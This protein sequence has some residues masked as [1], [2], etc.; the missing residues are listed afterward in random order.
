MVKRLRLL[1]AAVAISLVALL[2]VAASA[3]R[4]AVVL[5]ENGCFESRGR[6]ICVQ[7]P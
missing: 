3:G 5:D 6:T 4:G 2:P 7:Y 1:F